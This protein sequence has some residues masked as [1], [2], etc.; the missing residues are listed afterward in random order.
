MDRLHGLT[1]YRT[2]Q[3][4]TRGNVAQYL[5]EMISELAGVARASDMPALVFILSIAR[6]EALQSEANE[7][8]KRTKP[9]AIDP[10]SSA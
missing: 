4:A 3:S 10:H 9:S 1:F 2:V 8:D 5:A 7:A 6:Q